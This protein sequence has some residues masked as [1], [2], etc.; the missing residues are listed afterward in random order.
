MENKISFESMPL[1]ITEL[2]TKIDRIQ[3]DINVLKLRHTTQTIEPMIGIEEACKIL[4]RAKST[5]YALTQA[6]KIPFYQPGKMLQFK[7]SELMA[8]MEESKQETYSQ[9]Q[10]D[11]IAKMESTVHHKPRSKCMGMKTKRTAV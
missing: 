7:K 2:I 6:R 5:V 9:S 4:H 1:A 3:S 10:E 8:W 11:L